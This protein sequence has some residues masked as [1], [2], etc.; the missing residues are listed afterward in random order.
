[1][2]VAEAKKRY[3]VEHWMTTYCDT[4]G[5]PIPAS[6]VKPTDTVMNITIRILSSVCNM[7]IIK[8]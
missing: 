8:N 6:E 2:T 7:T 5:V 1:M 4:K 3:G